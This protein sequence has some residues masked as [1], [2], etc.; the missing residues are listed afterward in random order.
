[1]PEVVVF[2]AGITFHLGL[3]GELGR[4]SVGVGGVTVVS[5]ASIE[6]ALG[7]VLGA[8][9]KA[10]RFRPAVAGRSDAGPVLIG[11][12]IG[13]G[14]SVDFE[15]RRELMLPLRSPPTVPTRPAPLPKDVAETRSGLVFE[16]DPFFNTAGVNA[17]L[18]FLAGETSLVSVVDPRDRVG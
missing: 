1:M 11:W 15:A 2:E 3:L 10:G 4:W 7:G 17:S 14:F 16:F 12:G 13:D 9:F 5:G 6:E 8:V 18:S